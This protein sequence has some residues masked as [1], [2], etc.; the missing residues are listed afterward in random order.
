MKIIAQREALLA[1]CQTASA[2][3]P[4]KEIKPILKNLK[5]DCHPGVC[6]ISA[7]DLEVGVRAMVEGV[8]VLEPGPALLPAAKLI[9]MLRELKTPEVEITADPG[10]AEVTSDGVFY[11]LPGEDAD[12]FPSFPGFDDVTSSWTVPAGVLRESIHRTAFAVSGDTQRYAMSGVLWSFDGGTLRMVGTDG[13]RLALVEGACQGEGSGTLSAIIPAKTLGL[14][15]RTLSGVEADDTAEVVIRPN[16]V[17][18]RCGGSTVYSR[19][20][21]GRFPDYSSVLPKTSGVEV[22]LS[23]E[24]FSAGVRQAAIMTDSE[25]KRVTCSFAAGELTITGVGA[26]SGKSRVRQSIE[27]AGKTVSINFNPQYLLEFLKVV[28]VDAQLTLSLTSGEAPA[29]FRL[30]G[31]RYLVMPLT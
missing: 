12:A 30:D 26:G 11:E 25:T 31:Y 27:H 24:A 10:G 20:V 4:A 8:N 19:V 6:E 13:R 14:L 5:V 16:E 1:V 28:P 23:A 2:A 21:E 29:L 15:E 3:V 18:V 22:R 9:A 7:T 17:L